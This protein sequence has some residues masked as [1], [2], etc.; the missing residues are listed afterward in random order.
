MFCPKCRAEFVSGITICSDCGI[1]LV[2]RL[3]PESKPE[4]RKLVEVFRTWRI[5]EAGFVKSLLETNNV[6]CFIL[7]IHYP[8]LTPVGSGAVP[9]KIMVEEKDRVDAENIITQYYKDL[10]ENE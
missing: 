8:S 2:E 10:K 4:Y 3:P 7:N 1:P 9:I 6:N 5:I